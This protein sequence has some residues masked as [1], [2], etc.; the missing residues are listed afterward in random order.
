M[1]GD[2]RA[3]RGDQAALS[4]PLPAGG[5]DVAAFWVG[6]AEISRGRPA[7]DPTGL[8]FE[9]LGREPGRLGIREAQRQP[10]DHVVDHRAGVAELAAGPA[11][12]LEA[13]VRQ[14]TGVFRQRH[15]R[16]GRWRPSLS[17]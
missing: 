4:S 5:G 14:P 17:Y 8:P 6:R 16:W 3:V 7:A 10:A 1:A 9:Y 13:R 12:G 15:A 11:G 2:C